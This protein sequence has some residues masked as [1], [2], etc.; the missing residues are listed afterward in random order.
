MR[1]APRPRPSSDAYRTSAARRRTEDMLEKKL[2]DAI[3]KIFYEH[4]PTNF[5]Q[6]VLHM[7]N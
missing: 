4:E 1:S 7:E 2:A 6:G 5:G 3:A